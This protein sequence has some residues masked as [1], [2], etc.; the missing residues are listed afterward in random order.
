MLATR[1]TTAARPA[2]SQRRHA[3]LREGLDKS[4][5]DLPACAFSPAQVRNRLRGIKPLRAG[6]ASRPFMAGGS[7]DLFSASLAR[8]MPGED[9]FIQSLQALSHR[10]DR[11][12]GLHQRE[13]A[14]ADLA[15]I[16]GRI[17]RRFKGLDD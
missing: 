14:S 1:L 4:I 9:G 7:A 6:F 2:T 10:L 8:S 5:P 15:P 16:D 17:K 3:H 11:I 12:L 13:G